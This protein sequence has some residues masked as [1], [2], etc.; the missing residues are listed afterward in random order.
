MTKMIYFNIYKKR[1]KVNMDFDNVGDSE[2]TF[3][4]SMI[5]KQR[6][7]TKILIS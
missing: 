6:K 5:F 2:Q 1:P 4:N 7:N 3:I